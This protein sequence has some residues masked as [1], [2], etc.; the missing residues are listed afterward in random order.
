MATFNDRRAAATK[1]LSGMSSGEEPMGSNPN[2][3][4]VGIPGESSIDY[5]AKNSLLNSYGLSGGSIPQRK[6]YAG[7]E[8]VMQTTAVVNMR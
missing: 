6:M 7:I 5:L 8:P 1:D 2:F 4:V 3:F